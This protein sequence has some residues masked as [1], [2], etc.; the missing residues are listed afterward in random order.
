MRPKRL[1][2]RCGLEALHHVQQ[3]R[4]LGFEAPT[5][6]PGDRVR[7]QRGK[8][9]WRQGRKRETEGP[10]SESTWMASLLF[11]I[12]DPQ[13]LFKFCCKGNCGSGIESAA[14]G[15]MGWMRRAC[16]G[17][18]DVARATI[19]PSLPVNRESGTRRVLLPALF[20]GF[21]AERLFLAIA[22]HAQAIC[23]RCR[24]GSAQF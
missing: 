16:R 10:G 11:S 4:D 14:A 17:P 12:L 5:I 13:V 20:G 7:G 6:S 9:N 24:P 1:N 2:R 21:G 18:P 8:K 15:T 23:C 19:R 3:L 22:D